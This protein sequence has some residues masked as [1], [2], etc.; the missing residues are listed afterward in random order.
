MS[1]KTETNRVCK[2][3]YTSGSFLVF[4]RDVKDIIDVGSLFTFFFRSKK[5]FYD[6]A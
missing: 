4:V 2:G 3:E 1:S 5:R 6:D